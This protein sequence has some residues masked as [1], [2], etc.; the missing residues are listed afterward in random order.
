[1]LSNRRELSC[2]PF[3][4]AS[5]VFSNFLFNKKCFQLRSLVDSTKLISITSLNFHFNYFAHCWRW[6]CN[7]GNAFAVFLTFTLLWFSSRFLRE[8]TT[9]FLRFSFLFSWR[10]IICIYCEPMSR[11]KLLASESEMKTEAAWGSED[12]KRGWENIQFV[13]K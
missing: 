3:G 13:L 7:D 6:F 5:F 2:K 8:R 4:E 9:I 10:C 11:E 12:V 1:M